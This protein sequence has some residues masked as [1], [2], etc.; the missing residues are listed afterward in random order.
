[1]GDQ[2]ASLDVS[3]LD[4]VGTRLTIDN[5]IAADSLRAPVAGT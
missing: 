2:L 1:M 5:V 4:I 3:A